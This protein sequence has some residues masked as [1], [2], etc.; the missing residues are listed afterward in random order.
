MDKEALDK[1]E[2]AKTLAKLG[3]ES[4]ALPL[5]DSVV[6]A[7]P[8]AH[9]GY[10]VRSSILDRLGEYRRAIADVSNVIRLQPDQAGPLFRR[11]R[12]L[13]ASGD[14]KAAAVDFSVAMKFD[15]G[16]FGDAL[17]FYRAEALLRCKDYEGALRDCGA[18]KSDYSERSFFGHAKRSRQ[19]IENA[20][21]TGLA[22]TRG[23]STL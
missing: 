16:Y 8:D 20:A 23:R 1:L 21:R 17:H 7:Y 22:V 6:A 10:E 13:L 11:G 5:C 2:K 9:L 12:Y 19:D 18:M 4:E 15:N 14:C 3:L